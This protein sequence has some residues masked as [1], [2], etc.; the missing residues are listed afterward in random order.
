MKKLI[1]IFILLSPIQL[2]SVELIQPYYDSYFLTGLNQ[3][4][5]GKLKFSFK[6]PLFYP[7]EEDGI[8]LGYNQ[9]SKWNI[10][11]HSSPFKSTDYN[12]SIFYEINDL[13]VL[14]FVRIYPYSHTSNGR[15]GSESKSMDN[16]CLEMQAS[17]GDKFVIGVWEKLMGYYAEGSK[18]KP[19]L[20]YGNWKTKLFFKIMSKYGILSGFTIYA[21]GEW[22]HNRLD[23]KYYIEWGSSI[24][25]AFGLTQ[26]NLVYQGYRGVGEFFDRHNDFT[27]NSHRVGIGFNF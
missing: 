14:D 11:D 7:Y 8:N 1:L 27:D 25:L 9:L 17:I 18:S 2:F 22:L 21:Q 23:S 26:F 13:W 12:P 16:Y 4:T 5:Q 15:D 20:D 10:Y 6:I 3:Q 24:N 19:H